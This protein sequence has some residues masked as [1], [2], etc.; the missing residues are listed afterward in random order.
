MSKYSR[1][2]TAKCTIIVSLIVLSISF[3]DAFA[4]TEEPIPALVDG[5]STTLLIAI[6]AVIGVGLQT[7]KGMLGK[8]REDFDI[9]QLIFTFI[10]GVGASIILVGNAFQ[11]ISTDMNGTELMIFMVQQ[12]IT[13]MGAKTLTDIGSKF[14]PKSQNSI[15]IEPEPIDNPDDLP[16]GKTVEVT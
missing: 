4:Q 9:N 1:K 12:V 6:I 14:I 16:P 7:Y 5:M 15:P 10:V 2:N 3:G 11:N 8:K 13:V